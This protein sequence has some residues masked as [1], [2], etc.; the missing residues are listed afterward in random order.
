M[1]LIL[2]VFFILVTVGGCIVFCKAEDEFMPGVISVSGFIG[3]VISLI[4]TISLGVSVS[5]L[6][7]IDD[8]IAM[9]EE[10]NTKIESQISAAVE[11]Y[12]NYEKDIFTGV[13]GESVISLI[14]LYPELKA[15][16]LVQEQI[17]VYLANNAKIKSLKEEKINGDVKR[18]WL[19]FGG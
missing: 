6:N 15:D 5:K 1:I 11:S 3:F 8:K 18:W 16:T 13:K 12:Q 7:V 9:Y 4:V 2:L 19:Y 10:E 17:N 14:A